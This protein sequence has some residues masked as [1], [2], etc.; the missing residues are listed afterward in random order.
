M[1][2]QVLDYGAAS[3]RRIA[4]A[5][6]FS[7]IW[8]LSLL[9]DRGVLLGG[10]SSGRVGITA[11]E[12]SPVK[13]AIAKN[14]QDGNLRFIILMDA[15][16]ERLRDLISF[17]NERSRFAIYAVEM[18][19]YRHEGYEIV[20]PK[21]FGAERATGTGGTGGRRH[22]DE[23]SFLLRLQFGESRRAE[24]NPAAL[25][26]RTGYWS[27]CEM[28]ERDNH[29]LVQPP[30]SCVSVGSLFT[31]S[32]NGALDLNFAW[33]HDTPESDAFCERY[34]NQ[35]RKSGFCPVPPGYETRFVSAGV[36]WHS[37]VET[38]I[39]ALRPLVE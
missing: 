27:R 31:V 22:W 16:H 9:A 32:S 19:F 10:T 1:I 2:A 25:C 21:L 38:L 29:R 24:C 28:G 34:I 23:T 26:V 18:R 20:I 15:L 39:N 36:H 37:N 30:I 3:G 7:M 13:A 17:L 4:M 14:V 11:E 8:I 5:K 12:L 35:I 6:A 33:L